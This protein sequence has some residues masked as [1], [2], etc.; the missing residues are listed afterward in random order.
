MTRVIA[1]PPF[2]LPG[3]AQIAPTRVAF[4]LVNATG[5]P[6]AG[7]SLTHGIVGRKEV[8]ATDV[9]QLIELEINADISPFTLWRVTLTSG[10]TQQTVTVPLEAWPGAPSDEV[11]LPLAD[12]LYPIS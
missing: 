11:P 1:I 10:L 12:L 7:L 4:E 3:T 2:F 5:Q 8:V 6:I 9:E